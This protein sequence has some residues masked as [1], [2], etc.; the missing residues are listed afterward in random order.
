MRK[1]I[2]VFAMILIFIIPFGFSVTVDT[3]DTTAA[4]GL[5]GASPTPTTGAGS[6]SLSTTGVRGV[7]FENLKMCINYKFEPFVT[8][9]PDYFVVH[10]RANGSICDCSQEMCN[11]EQAWAYIIN[12]YREL[13]L[14][15]SDFSNN[16]MSDVESLPLYVYSG[17][18]NVSNAYS[19]LGMGDVSLGVDFHSVFP[20]ASSIATDASG[21]PI[22]TTPQYM[23]LPN[24]TSTYY[25]LLSNCP[26]EGAV[27]YEAACSKYYTY[28]ELLSLPPLYAGTLGGDW[29]S[30]SHIL[31]TDARYNGLSGLGE[32]KF[33][34]VDGPMAAEFN[35]GYSTQQVVDLFGK[36][37]VVLWLEPVVVNPNLKN[38]IC[39]TPQNM[40]KFLQGC[41]LSTDS[42]LGNAIAGTLTWNGDVSSESKSLGPITPDFRHI[43]CKNVLAGATGCDSTQLNDWLWNIKD[44]VSM[45]NLCGSAEVCGV[46]EG[47]GVGYKF[48][49]GPN[50]EWELQ[51]VIVYYKDDDGYLIPV[52]PPAYVTMPGDTLPL[53][54]TLLDNDH[55]IVY[56]L[57]GFEYRFTFNFKS[58]T[59]D[60]IESVWV[61]GTATTTGLNN[62][63]TQY[64]PFE[65]LEEDLS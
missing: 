4:S 24:S 23:R 42:L 1:N 17:Y 7:P 26:T 58:K 59:N 10:D 13:T 62:M 60:S 40:N 39:S 45:G 55:V 21:N 49:I 47:G 50:T 12:R 3:G 31:P 52:D 61:R 2:F 48:T 33:F 35:M 9:H 37:G 25:D 56:L 14:S 16:A 5:S 18:S 64:S 6:T 44:T 19:F 34:L 54:S 38:G 8:E 53:S 27:N 51:D 65:D 43:W 32:K 36:D 63:R 11:I 57:Q 20:F 41:Y 22:S 29:L 30:F 46:F 15:E 28:L